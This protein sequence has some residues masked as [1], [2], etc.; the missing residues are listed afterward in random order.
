[1]VLSER[2]AGKFQMPMAKWIGVKPPPPTSPSLHNIPYVPGKTLSEACSPGTV[3]LAL[4]GCD[5]SR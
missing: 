5:A 4:D 1:M 3:I 2:I